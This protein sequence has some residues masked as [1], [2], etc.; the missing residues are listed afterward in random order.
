MLLAIVHVYVANNA[1]AYST[2]AE[3]VNKTASSAIATG[4]NGA[5]TNNQLLCGNIDCEHGN[6]FA[7]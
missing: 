5:D 4:Y 6:S 3:G 2:N 7:E 1:F